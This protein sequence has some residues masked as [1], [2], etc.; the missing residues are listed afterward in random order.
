M[1]VW[2]VYTSTG[3]TGTTTR[4]RYPVY[5]ECTMFCDAQ[6]K[7]EGGADGR[8]RCEQRYFTRG[9]ISSERYTVQQQRT[10]QGY[11][12]E[13]MRKVKFVGI[14]RRT[15]NTMPKKSTRNES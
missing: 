7:S 6:N 4:L 13:R 2:F 11:D 12:D 8:A 3:T 1:N 10:E 14:K 15:D 5:I 9:V